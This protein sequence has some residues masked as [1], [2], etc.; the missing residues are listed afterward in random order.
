[1]R[2]ALLTL[3]MF[4]ATA[5]LCLAANIPMNISATVLS[6]SICRFVTTKT[7]TVDFG[8]LDPTAP[9]DV[10]VTA[11]LTVR[12]QGSADPATY[13]IT[14]DDGLYETGVNANRMQHST[15]PGNFI[16]YTVTYTPASDTIPKNFNQ[17]L[18]ITGTLLGADY[19]TAIA[20]VYN[21]TVTLT[22]AP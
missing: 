17:T 22:L 12:C 3:I 21:D 13:L 15:A 6:K 19:T 11:S 5:Q 1:M 20:G 14:D 7:A 9:T 2:R 16:P 8:N 4:L 10:V 18:T